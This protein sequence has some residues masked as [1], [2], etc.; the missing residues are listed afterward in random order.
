ME[1]K[2]IFFKETDSTN[3]RIHQMAKEGALEGT[4]AW[5]DYQAAGKGRRGRSWE[6]PAGTN[7]YF[8][9]LLRPQI[10]PEKAPML[11]IVMAYSVAKAIQN[12]LRIEPQIKWPN[13]LIL[14]QKKICGILT[15]MHLGNQK[16]SHVVIGVGMN[17]N[18]TDFPKEL[19]DKATSIYL[20]T[21]RMV[22]REMLLYQV[23]KEFEK[24]YNLF[25]EKQ[26][27]GFLQKAYNQILVN[28]GKE[29]LVLEP[30][31]EYQGTALG[32]NQSGEL[33]V[34][35]EDGAV[36]AVFAGEVSVRGIYGYV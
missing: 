28:K 24:Q 9:I 15:E 5:A 23:L 4:V 32:I 13:D 14:N 10:L 11:T 21:G 36:E 1:N 27:L 35:K 3:I 25:L 29:V 19:E 17:V 2:I 33:L 8:S 12:L 16:I 22:E 18:V 26:D 34:E 6:S 30:G 7:L 31:H 20:E